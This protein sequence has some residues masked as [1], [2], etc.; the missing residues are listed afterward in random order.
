MLEK[1]V[2]PPGLEPGTRGLRARCSRYLAVAALRQ[3][4]SFGP[5]EGGPENLPS[6]H[7]AACGERVTGIGRSPPS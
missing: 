5:P 3:S 6:I 1:V 2:D 7:P 4:R